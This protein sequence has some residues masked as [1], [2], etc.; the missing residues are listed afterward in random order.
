MPKEVI[1]LGQLVFNK[2]GFST[3]L[4]ALCALLLILIWPGGACARDLDDEFIKAVKSGETAIVQTLLGKGANVNA[5]DELTNTA[6]GWAVM[7]DHL[8]CATLLIEKGADVNIKSFRELSPLHL[9]TNNHNL[10]MVKILLANRADVNAVDQ[11]QWTALMNAIYLGS[12]KL[13]DVLLASGADVNAKNY[14]GRTSLYIAENLG[15]TKIAQKLIASG[16]TSANGIITGTIAKTDRGI[17]LSVD[18]GDTYIVM[19]KDLS[20]MIGQTVK[21][22]GTLAEGSSG[23]TLTVISFEPVQK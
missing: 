5:Q 2:V 9:A 1:M 11:Y 7:N 22:T 18:N 3:I 21:V 14:L 13:V 19:G 10:Q 8:E 15:H 17:V 23:K 16:A 6:L 4:L 12:S 20:E